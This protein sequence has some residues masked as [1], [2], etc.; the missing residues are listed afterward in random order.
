MTSEAQKEIAEWLGNKVAEA[1]L[2]AAA[3]DLLRELQ[4]IEAEWAFRE[5]GLEGARRLNRWERERLM[6]IRDAIKKATSPQAQ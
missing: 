2:R 5:R 6:F 4:L 1:Q 3:P